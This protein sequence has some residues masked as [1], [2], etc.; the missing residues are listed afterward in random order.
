MPALAANKNDVLAACMWD[1]MP[2]TTAAYA[3]AT[4]RQQEFGLFVKAIGPC[5]TNGHSGFP[6]SN[7]NLTAL[8]K[9]V[10]KLRP[11]S[12]GPDTVQP[13]ASVC[14]QQPDGSNQCKPAGQ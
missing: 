14:L 11:Q 13:N 12:I 5:N 2:T 3:D 6:G 10:V 4:D 8:K 1:K 7:V 9:A